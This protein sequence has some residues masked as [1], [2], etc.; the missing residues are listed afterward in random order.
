MPLP[1]LPLQPVGSSLPRRGAGG[2]CGPGRPRRCIEPILWADLNTGGKTVAAAKTALP[3]ALAAGWPPGA[4]GIV[5]SGDGQRCPVRHFT[6]GPALTMGG[7]AQVSA[8]FPS[9]S[10]GISEAGTL[11]NTRQLSGFLWKNAGRGVRWPAVSPQ[12]LLPG[13]KGGLMP[14]NWRALRVLPLQRLRC[15]AG[16]SVPDGCGTGSAVELVPVEL[17]DGTAACH[18]QGGPGLRV[19]EDSGD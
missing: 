18:R 4:C 3:S 19:K 9:G 6:R 8:S 12:A 13:P 15:P 5:L 11:Q 7:T 1:S 2:Q 17:T 10:G 16:T 14:Q